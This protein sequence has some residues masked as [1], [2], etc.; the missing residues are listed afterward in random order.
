MG[1]IRIY[2][3]TNITVGPHPAMFQIFMGH[4]K[5]KLRLFSLGMEW[6]YCNCNQQSSTLMATRR[7]VIKRG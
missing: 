7:C 2:K 3:P 1:I 6:E 4:P 5:N